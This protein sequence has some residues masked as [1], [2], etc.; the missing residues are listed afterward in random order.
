MVTTKQADEIIDVVL[1][2]VYIE[3]PHSDD[4]FPQMDSNER[5]E[6]ISL[7]KD[8]IEGK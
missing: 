4:A 7:I 1:E 8:I 6:L 3:G 2:R 5:N